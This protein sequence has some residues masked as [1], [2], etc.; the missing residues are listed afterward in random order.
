MSGEGVQQ[1]L[2][3]MVEGTI[4]NVPKEGGRKN[5]RGEFIQVRFFRHI[6][7]FHVTLLPLFYLSASAVLLSTLSSSPKAFSL[8]SP[9]LSS[10]SHKVDTTNILFVAAGAFAGL[11]QVV[12]RRV[13]KASIGFG[14]VLKEDVGN[15][16]VCRITTGS[17][18]SK[19]S[20]PATKKKSVLFYFSCVHHFKFSRYPLKIIIFA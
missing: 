1:A 6:I 16:E 7:G 10:F 3:K 20:R 9:T 2:L 18:S 11:E 8:S 4:V 17:G 19:V 5:P 14:A 12:N 15:A 13:A